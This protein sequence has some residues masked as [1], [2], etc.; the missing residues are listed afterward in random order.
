MWRSL[1]THPELCC[2]VTL[3]AFTINIRKRVASAPRNTKHGA[4]TSGNVLQEPP[5]SPYGCYDEVHAKMDVKNLHFSN[6]LESPGRG[7]GEGLMSTW[8]F[9]AGEEEGYPQPTAWISGEEE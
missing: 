3:E 1:E 2:G 6:L 7:L 9:F 4:G 5:A 8:Q